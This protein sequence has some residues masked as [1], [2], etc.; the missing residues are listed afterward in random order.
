MHAHYMYNY[1]LSSFTCMWHIFLS[2]AHCHFRS[3]HTYKGSLILPKYCAYG[4]KCYINLAVASKQPKNC[5]LQ[6]RTFTL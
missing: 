3:L 4:F 2:L 6:L 5:A 1:R